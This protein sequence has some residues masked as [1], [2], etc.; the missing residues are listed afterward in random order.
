[1][2]GGAAAPGWLGRRR[3][4][5]EAHA[6]LIFALLCLGGLSLLSAIPRQ[7]FPLLPLI[8]IW[9]IATGERAMRVELRRDT[10]P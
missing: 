7:V 6:M 5:P 10:E 9:C 8:L 3:L 2:V 1:V 4:P